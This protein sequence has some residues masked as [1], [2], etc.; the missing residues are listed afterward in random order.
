MSGIPGSEKI[1]EDLYP[2]SSK[3]DVINISIPASLSS[4]AFSGI[5]ISISRRWKQET[6][7]TLCEV[8]VFLG[9]NY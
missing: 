2:Y 1:F 4:T 5:N 9:N 8:K 3:E 6:F 7:L